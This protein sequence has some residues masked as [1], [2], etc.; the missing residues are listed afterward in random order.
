M[1]PKKKADKKKSADTDGAKSAPNPEGFLISRQLDQERIDN[2][3]HRVHDLVTSNNQLRSSSNRNERDT[4]DIVLFFQREMEMKDEIITRL[5]EELV[6]R[7]T[8]LKFEVEKMKKR[9][10]TDLG[11]MKDEMEA[12][13]NDLQTKLDQAN[14]DLTAVEQYVLEKN[15][16]DENTARLE[17]E[18]VNQRQQMFDALEEQERRFLEEKA[19]L[20]RDLDDQKVAFREVALKE[21]RDTL[22]QEARKIMSENSRMFEELKFQNVVTSDLMEERSQ[23]QQQLAAAKRECSILS[24]KELEYA[25]AAFFKSKE[26][27]QLRE[28]V[29]V[30]EKQH[31][32]QGEQYRA[33]TKDLQA[34]VSKELEEASL[35]AAGLRKLIKIK[36]QELRQM[37]TL[38]TTILAQ[39]TELETFFHESLQEVKDCIKKER[40][41]SQ[42]ETKMTL[43]KMR[44]GG[45]KGGPKLPVLNVKGANLHLVDERGATALG[46]GM[47]EQVS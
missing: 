8:Q 46:P 31:L 32:V 5:N 36:N 25:R 39:R 9:F 35:D 24:E 1:G 13:I 11:V 3:S 30:L 7:E 44:G 34:S 28:R 29:E 21:A 27:K 37:K 2:L 47:S 15:K 20:L 6:K 41:R 17:S 45:D 40:K 19:A 23:I 33:K 38:A 26:L 10:D 14:L 4:H 12:I 42:S 18:L 16:H 22:G 43:S